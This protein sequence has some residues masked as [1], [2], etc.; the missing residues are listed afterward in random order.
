MT[1]REQHVA[2]VIRDVT[3]IP[4]D[5]ILVIDNVPPENDLMVC[6]GGIFYTKH[7]LGVKSE[8]VPLGAL[9]VAVKAE[10]DVLIMLGELEPRK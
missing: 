4:D 5:E 3:G 10:L 6:F 2:D 8:G 7:F 9:T 1:P